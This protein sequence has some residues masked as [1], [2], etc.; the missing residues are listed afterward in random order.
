[1][2]LNDIFD[3]LGT[4]E[5]WWTAECVVRGA[6]MLLLAACILATLWLHRSVHRPPTHDANAREWLAAVTVV[7]GGCGGGVLTLAGPGLFERI[8]APGRRYSHLSIGDSRHG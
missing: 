2:T 7:A 8:S 5:R 1:M 3:R 4:G 6:G